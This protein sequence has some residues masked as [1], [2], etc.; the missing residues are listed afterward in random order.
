MGAFIEDGG[1]SESSRISLTAPVFTSFPTIPSSVQNVFPDQ[2]L[3]YEFLRPLDLPSGSSSSSL[4]QAAFALVASH[5]A[6]TDNIVFGVSDH[7][8]I[9]PVTVKLFKDQKVQDYMQMMQE[10]T[11]DVSQEESNNAMDFQTLLRLY[12]S[13]N[14]ITSVSSIHG[15]GDIPPSYFKPPALTIQLQQNPGQTSLTAD[16]DPRVIDTWLVQQLLERLEFVLHQL[17]ESSPDQQLNHIKMMTPQDQELIWELNSTVPKV[18]ERCIHDLIKEQVDARPNAPAVNAWDGDF[19]Y[20]EL[21][22]LA[23]RL[24]SQLIRLGIKADMLVPVCF[25]KSKW[26]QVAALAVLKAGGGFV[27]LDS[28]LPESRLRSICDQLGSEVILSSKNNQELSARLA[29]LV[30]RVDL[31]SIQA[32]DFPTDEQSQSQPPSPSSAMYTVFTS[33]STGA[34]KGV[35]MTHANFCT[36]LHYQLQPFRYTEESRSFDFSSYAF[37]VATYNMIATFVSGGCLCVPEEKDRRESLGESMAAFRATLTMLTPTVARLLDPNTLPDMKTVILLGEAVFGKDAEPWWGKSHVINAYGPAE[38]VITTANWT[39]KT[40]DEVMHIG[41]GVGL[42][43]WVVDPEDHNRLLAPGL[44][45][46]L[47]MEGPLVGRGYLDKP[48]QTAKAFIE[49]PEFLVKGTAKY[50]GRH[51]RLYK[52]G[53]LVRYNN[54][55]GSLTYMGRKDTQVKIRG[56]RVELSEIEFHVQACVPGVSQAIAEMIKPKG[57]NADPVLAAFVEL[58]DR[59]GAAKTDAIDAVILEIS[60]ETQQKLEKSLPIYMVPSVLFSMPAI[61]STPTGKTDRKRLREIGGSLTVSE[62]A[63]L[64]TVSQGTK[65]Q[66]I[67]EIEKQL[68]EI[69]CRALKMQPAM[70]GMDDTF[71]SLGGNS[72]D[73]MKVV[74]AARG[75]S[76]GLSIADIIQK[77]TIARISDGI[78]MI[79]TST[80]KEQAPNGTLAAVDSEFRGVCKYLLGVQSEDIEAIF[81]CSPTQEYILGV[82]HQDTTNYR[83]CL[84][85]E[86]QLSGENAKLDLDRLEQAWRELVNRHGMLRTTFV[87]CRVGDKIKR[88]FVTLKNVEPS[89]S[90]LKQGQEAKA[91]DVRNNG[92][93]FYKP[94]GP[95]HHLTICKVDEQRAFL[96][97]QI[98]HAVFDGFSIDIFCKDLRAAYHG[99]LGPVG[100][101]GDFIRYLQAQPREERLDFWSNHLADAYPTLFPLSAGVMDECASYRPFSVP[102]IDSTRIRAFCAEWQLMHP[103]L[104]HTAWSFVLSAYTGIKTPIFGTFCLGR[105]VPVDKSER[106][107][108]PF[109]GLIPYKVALNKPQTVIETL[110]VAQ[111]DYLASTAYQHTS[112]AEIE[113]TPMFEGSKLFNSHITYQKAW[114]TGVSTEDPLTIKY[115]EEWDPNDYEVG[116]RPIET[117]EGFDIQLNFRAGCL[118]VKMATRLANDYGKAISLILDNPSLRFEDLKL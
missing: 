62:L 32:L 28:T 51:G 102:G 55:D 74:A 16:Y 80:P 37:D 26:T 17:N 90:Y 70:V 68:Q 14:A 49:D 1:S 89:I 18:V 5:M 97:L 23:S 91:R 50:P 112:V 41:K 22:E 86:V 108:G 4:V 36:A 34:P 11:E 116:V 87:H 83:L 93:P 92:G 76:I 107:W 19:T 44:V 96:Q 118:S 59:A 54:K 110:Q 111:S 13:P 2:S 69:W 114:S 115:A 25:E 88:H 72:I 15:N 33:G 79:K 95:Q 48:E 40:P 103:T 113:Q 64:R 56:Q 24:A 9:V 63:A 105:D 98:N 65:R 35:I 43:C 57:E 60:E 67:N 77:K 61:P 38:C 73:A 46:E 52:S 3:K 30:V 6:S 27:L 20:G 42:V 39:A 100:N 7:N 85:F 71:A 8:R 31:E 45:G 94:N 82:Q 10:E 117:P 104:I 78:G 81:P 12:S 99:N 21:D 75:S 84:G 53:D 101:Y 66:P 106:T 109:I 58:G 47:L 29:Q